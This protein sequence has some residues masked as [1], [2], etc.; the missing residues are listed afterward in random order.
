MIEEKNDQEKSLLVKRSKKKEPENV[1]YNYS[2]DFTA[3][4]KQN[5]DFVD[6][7][8]W[9]KLEL[10]EKKF[11]SLGSKAPVLGVE[12]VEEKEPRD[13]L[14]ML[15]EK[16]NEKSVSIIQKETSLFNAKEL[17]NL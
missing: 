5:H 4:A 6:L 1:I 14:K 11:K 17:Q 13:Y 16:E 9:N 10:A 8:D 3:R 15:Q 12:K 7:K 2:L